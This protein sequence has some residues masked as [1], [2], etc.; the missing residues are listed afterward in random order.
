M[1]DEVPE[2]EVSAPAGEAGA[3]EVRGHELLGELSVERHQVPEGV[4]DLPVSPGV[5]V[6][7]LDRVTAVLA[8]VPDGVGEGVAARQRFPEFRPQRGGLRPRQPEVAVAEG[9]A[10]LVGPELD[11]D[12]TAEFLD[13]EPGYSGTWKTLGA[14]GP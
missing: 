4:E 12:A 2:Q 13:Q 5:G 3:G 6:A 7:P 11:V 8:A 1:L 14:P 10:N 9:D